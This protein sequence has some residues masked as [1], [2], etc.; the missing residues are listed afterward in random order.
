VD[1]ILAQEY[2]RS[3]LARVDKVTEDQT[4]KHYETHNTNFIT[5]ATVKAQ[6]ILIKIDP[7][8]L[9]EESKVALAKVLKIKKE[10]DGG[11]DFAKAAEQCS[12][13]PGSKTN[14]GDL[15]Y[16]ASDRMVRNFHQRPSS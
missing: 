3:I 4:T 8:A 5:P 2:L 12:D 11:A 6:H 9:P 14:G 1:N 7:K 16:F 10:L 13:D 15:G